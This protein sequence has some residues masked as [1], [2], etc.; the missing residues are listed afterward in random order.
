MAAK[1]QDERSEV[2][3][4][5]IGVLWYGALYNNVE[6]LVSTLAEMERP[7][8]ALQRKDMIHLQC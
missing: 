1:G 5:V 4:V 6:T 7:G 3:G 2:D 8:R